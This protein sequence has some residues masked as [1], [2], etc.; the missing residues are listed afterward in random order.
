MF[1]FKGFDFT[2][3]LPPDGTITVINDLDGYYKFVPSVPVELVYVVDVPLGTPSQRLYPILRGN[4][5]SHFKVATL[6]E[7]LSN[8]QR[9]LLDKIGQELCKM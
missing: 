6:H 3:T 2:V 5:N 9:I 7:P 1:T 4:V 8:G